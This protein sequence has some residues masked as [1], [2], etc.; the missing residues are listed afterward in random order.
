MH[1]AAAEAPP[2][3]E[4]CGRSWRRAQWKHIGPSMK[5]NCLHEAYVHDE[6]G[7]R[8]GT[9]SPPVMRESRLQSTAFQVRATSQ[10]YLRPDVPPTAGSCGLSE[11]A[12]RRHTS[13]SV[14]YLLNRHALRHGSCGRRLTASKRG[15]HRG[16]ARA[17]YWQT[18]DALVLEE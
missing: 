11:V 6:I 8:T 5:E 16:G 12:H 7:A 1:P 10:W 4:G 3:K 2:P 18:C 9:C 13:P 14:Q 15:G 17:N